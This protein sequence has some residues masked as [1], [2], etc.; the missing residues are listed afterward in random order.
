[1]LIPITT[2]VNL[3]VDSATDLPYLRSFMDDND[4]KINISKLDKELSMGSADCQEVS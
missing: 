4:L 1:M 3:K 2:P